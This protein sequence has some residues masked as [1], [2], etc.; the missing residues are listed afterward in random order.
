[1][2]AT[3][4][5]GLRLLDASYCLNTTALGLAEA[6]KHFP[7]LAYLDLSRTAPARDV[8][9]LSTLRHMPHLQVLKLRRLHLRDEDIDILAEAIGCTIRSLDLRDNQLTD[10]SV[11][12]LL[13]KCFKSPKEAALIQQQ[14][15]SSITG[16]WPSNSG[17][18]IGLELHP[19]Y[20]GYRQDE[21]VRRSLTTG[22]V[23]HLGIESVCGTGL[24]HLYISGNR[25]T[26]E[27]VSGL[28]R[29]KRL[30]VLDV[31]TLVTGLVRQP[32]QSLVNGEM[33]FMNMPGAQKLIPILDKY[34]KDLRY[35]RI[36]HAVVTVD[37]PEEQND[38]KVAELEDTSGI[39]L[40]PHLIE[41]EAVDQAVHEMPGLE[42]Q[43][44]PP[45]NFPIAELEGSPVPPRADSP[46]EQDLSHQTSPDDRTPR[47][48]LED[49]TPRTSLE[50]HSPRI[51]LEDH[52][53]RIS[54]QDQSPR[55]SLGDHTLHT[56]S[57]DHSRT[58]LEESMAQTTLHQPAPHMMLVEPRSP[59]IRRGSAFAPEPV[60]LVSPVVESAGTLLMSPLSPQAG[61]IPAA[62]FSPLS[63]IAN[64]SPLTFPLP[65]T[66][67]Q[68]QP[69]AQAQPAA[70]PP[71]PFRLSVPRPPSPTPSA[72]SARSTHSARSSLT[73][74]LNPPLTAHKRTH[75]AILAAHAA[76][77]ATLL[78]APHALL[79]SMLP[80]L[81]TLVLTD[82]PAR[83]RSAAP[84]AHLVRFVAAV[85][86]E[87]HWAG[88]RADGEWAVPPGWS[89]ERRA[90]RD[91]GRRAWLR[92]GL[93]ALAA[94]VLEVG[95][96]EGAAEQPGSPTSP[97]SPGA[98]YGPERRGANRSWRHSGGVG[99]IPDSKSSVEDPDC[100]TFWDAASNDFS[101]F[102][103]EECGQPDGEATLGWAGMVAM[104][105]KISV[106][107]DGDAE[108]AWDGHR[109]SVW[110]E[111]SVDVNRSR[112][113]S[114][115]PKQQVKMYDVLS[116]LSKFRK[117]KK[118][119]R[120]MAIARGETDP[121]VEGYWDGDI[122]VVRP[123]D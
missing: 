118:R 70:L 48:S 67:T 21:H 28:I 35:L 80:R 29:S 82:V 63:P 86:R 102:G 9:V 71:S 31:G 89:G 16:D 33:K 72:H 4:T 77:V 50:D 103:G 41:L 5:Y 95:G 40:P 96:D 13:E 91:A 83:A 61:T 74:S 87:A 108:D 93:F 64:A 23:S 101:F 105:E 37:A 107:D 7:A 43:E 92:R 17:P 22:F 122:I 56:P 65:P 10:Q 97:A 18:R 58:S 62:L 42:P 110:T 120:E 78:S 117:E 45:D 46:Q 60:T 1:M 121:Y 99:T 39:V 109:G 15:Q 8:S 52:S 44:L 38:P 26:V 104:G 85:A 3:P 51:S 11:R 6:F 32:S 84:A 69:Q 68:P 53:S 81:Q 116:E 30:L 14:M 115:P 20:Q 55:T 100:E 90:G 2:D 24:T 73:S 25:L 113:E 94:V 112:R 75:S 27:G 36:N 47:T 106:G 79:P 59:E 19:D 66:P 34:G 54:L 114:L 111:G 12:I 49:G 76:H 88:L 57:S 119:L 123:K 98:A